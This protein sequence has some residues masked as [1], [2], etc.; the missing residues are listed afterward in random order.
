MRCR[1]LPLLV[2]PLLASAA[3]EPTRSGLVMSG[4]SSEIL[5]LPEPDRS[6]RLARAERAKVMEFFD[7]D[8]LERLLSMVKPE[9][10][11]EMLTFFQYR[12]SAAPRGLIMHLNDPQLQAVLEEVWAPHWDG[13]PDDAIEKETE[14]VPGREIARQRR[15][16]RRRSEQRPG[17]TP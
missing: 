4:P 9:L 11:A 14:P 3:C 8:A 15:E 5:R 16:A 12:D 17:G 13:L 10:R 6:F 2:L 7:V 1:M